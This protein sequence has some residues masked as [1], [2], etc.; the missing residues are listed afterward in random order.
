[1]SYNSI[2]SFQT[3]VDENLDE[4]I[5]PE[6]LRNGEWFSVDFI[7]PKFDSP[8]TPFSPIIILLLLDGWKQVVSESH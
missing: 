3:A 7:S 8:L 5:F 1:M 4:L 2:A 6:A